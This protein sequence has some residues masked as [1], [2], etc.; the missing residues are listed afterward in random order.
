MFHAE[1]A[2]HLAMELENAAMASGA[3]DWPA[4]SALYAS[5][6]AEMA[7]LRPLFENY[8]TTRVIP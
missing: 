1:S 4:C 2:R 5:L 6:A 3:V 8:L 7:Y